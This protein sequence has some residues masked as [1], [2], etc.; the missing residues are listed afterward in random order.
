[1]SSDRIMSATPVDTMS[2][3]LSISESV[4]DSTSQ[5]KKVGIE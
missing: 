5:K 4:T 1:M 2:H 3:D